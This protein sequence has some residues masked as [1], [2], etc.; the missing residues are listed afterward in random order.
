MS[1]KARSAKEKPMAT[2]LGV[3]DHPVKEIAE[4]TSLGL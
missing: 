1:K 2:S 4:C 3:K